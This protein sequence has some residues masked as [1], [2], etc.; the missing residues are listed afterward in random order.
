MCRRVHRFAASCCASWHTLGTPGVAHPRASLIVTGDQRMPNTSVG[1]R[2]CAFRV[3]S[4]TGS[5]CRYL[6]V[7]SQP[8]AVSRPRSRLKPAG[9]DEL[10]VQ[11]VTPHSTPSRQLRHVSFPNP[12]PS[13]DHRRRR[14][15]PSDTSAMRYVTA[16]SMETNWRSEKNRSL[17]PGSE[18]L[19][20][21][22]GF[23]R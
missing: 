8:V 7:M 2:S 14:H 19:R 4:P 11:A 12:F 17:R 3:S 20:H 10:R 13:G 18:S 6:W 1:S 15:S 5:T 21:R 22:S 23:N 16:A 9:H